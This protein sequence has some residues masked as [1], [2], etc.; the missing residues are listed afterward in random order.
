MTKKF[1][2]II[3][4]SLLVL[5]ACQKGEPECYQPTS[6]NATLSFIARNLERID[7]M[8]IDSIRIDS[9]FVIYR[10]TPM[11]APLM[12]SLNTDIKL[13]IIGSAGSSRLPFTFNP[14]S[15]N[16]QYVIQ[17]D[18]NQAFYDTMHLYYTSRVE[19]ISNDC[20]FTNYYHIDSLYVTK[21]HIDSFSLQDREVTMEGNLR[22]V[23]LF[24][25]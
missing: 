1:I 22:H 2:Q 13:S 9:T 14:A 18:T 21:N 23:L 3:S 15:G 10:D 11:I 20:G 7:T 12:H 6:V 17:F 5:I 16:I 4:F 24:F 25:F 19:F 8:T